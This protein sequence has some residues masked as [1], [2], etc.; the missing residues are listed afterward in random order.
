MTFPS[1][2]FNNYFPKLPV[3]WSKM[4]HRDEL[5]FL[6]WAEDIYCNW[7]CLADGQQ[8]GLWLHLFARE[9]CLTIAAGYLFYGL[10]SA[11]SPKR[12][13]VLWM[14]RTPGWGSVGAVC[15]AGSKLPPESLSPFLKVL[16]GTVADP[17]T[18]QTPISSKYLFWIKHFPEKNADLEGCSWHWV[19][20]ISKNQQGRA[21]T[22]VLNGVMGP[23]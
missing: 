5:Y 8:Y 11:N 7:L 3:W 15:N 12:S 16:D 22:I 4:K 9:D 6:S 14:S 2:S 23:L 10:Q 20:R 1:K 13:M 18:V 21:S 19:G 17:P